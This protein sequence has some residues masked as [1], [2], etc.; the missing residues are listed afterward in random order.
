MVKLTNFRFLIDCYHLISLF[1]FF[2]ELSIIL[3]IVDNLSINSY[4]DNKIKSK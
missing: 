4:G 3:R 1:I 2:I